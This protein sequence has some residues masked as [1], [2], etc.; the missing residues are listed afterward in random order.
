MPMRIIEHK[1]VVSRV[2]RTERGKSHLEIAATLGAEILSGVRAPGSRL[3]SAEEMFQKFGVSRIVMRE[4][5][6]TLAAKGMVTPKARVGTK[7]SDP[8]YWNWLDPQVLEWRS[9][10]GLDH[11]FITQLTQVRLALEPAAASLAAENRTEQDLMSLRAAIGG[12][13]GSGDDHQKFSQADRNFHDAVITATHNPFFQIPQR[14]PGLL[15]S[16]LSKAMP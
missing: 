10:I 9:K 8:A 2:R 5:T 12:M 16:R 1:P 7:V 13:Y 14:L 11:V 15:K 4:V 3:P 6:R